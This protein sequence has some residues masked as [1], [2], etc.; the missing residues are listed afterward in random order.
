MIDES[1][2]TPLEILRE[3]TEL[4][5]DNVTSNAKKIAKGIVGI[6][7]TLFTGFFGTFVSQAGSFSTAF[8]AFGL[9]VLSS[10]FLYFYIKSRKEVTV[11][12][13]DQ[14]A[15]AKSHLNVVD[16]L[17]DHF[18][19]EIQKSM[20]NLEDL[21]SDTIIGMTSQ[22]TDLIKAMSD[23]RDKLHTLMMV[24]TTDATNGIENMTTE[25]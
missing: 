19:I 21:Y 24:M 23:E 13:S 11:L 20:K 4:S 14:L 22:I 9:V 12:K 10:V 2:V 18:K 7:L 8:L 6:V 1:K 15:M 17:N 25:G 5:E 16:T 3:K